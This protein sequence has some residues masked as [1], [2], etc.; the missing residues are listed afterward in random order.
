M[1]VSPST[2][3][4]LTITHIGSFWIN[5]PVAAITFAAM[6]FCFKS[7][8]K[9]SDLDAPFL[10]RLIGLDL[11]GCALLLGASVQFF[12]ALQLNGQGQSWSSG[13]I[14]GPL[15]GSVVTLTIFML[16][17]HYKKDKALMPPRVMLQRNVAASCFMSFFLYAAMLIHSYYLPMYAPLLNI[18][19]FNANTI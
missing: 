14:L 19:S 6:V 17:Q 10:Q 16:W 9:T 1:V 13:P 3:H 4:K 11:I 2:F 18:H 12:I 15:L 8:S 7:Q 5:L